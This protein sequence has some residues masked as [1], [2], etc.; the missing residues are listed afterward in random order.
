MIEFFTG[1]GGMNIFILFILNFIILNFYRSVIVDLNCHTSELLF[2]TK[3]LLF[4]NSFNLIQII[5]S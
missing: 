3:L 1:I 5:I 4:H 2:E